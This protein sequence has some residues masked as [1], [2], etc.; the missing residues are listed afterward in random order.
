MT[1]FRDA[2]AASHLCALRPRS[3]SEGAPNERPRPPLRAAL[4]FALLPANKPQLRLMHRGLGCWAGT[5]IMPAL[6][7][8]S[9]FGTV[10][11]LPDAPAQASETCVKDSRAA[12]EAEA[13]QSLLH[14]HGAF[15][16]GQVG[17]DFCVGEPRPP[18]DTAHAHRPLHDE[19]GDEC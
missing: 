1:Q 11:A 12:L 15:D 17:L 14:V 9:L 2:R 10:M 19:H 8:V 13:V 5:I 18:C 3:M 6:V 4:G 7:A 16:A